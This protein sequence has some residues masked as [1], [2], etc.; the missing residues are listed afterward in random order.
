MQRK[1]NAKDTANMSQEQLSS[2]SSTTTQSQVHWTDEDNRALIQII[3]DLDV[4]ENLDRPHQ[5]NVN[6]YTQVLQA[7][8]DRDNTKI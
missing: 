4:M 1:K 8:A 6:I 2:T 5:R 3:A 7:L